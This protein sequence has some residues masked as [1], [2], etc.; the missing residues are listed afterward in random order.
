MARIISSREELSGKLGGSVY[1]RNKGGAY[2]RIFTIPINPRSQ[3]QLAVRNGW[4]SA[5]TA[6]HALSDSQKANWNYFAITDYKPKY[7]KIGISYS[8]FNCF[9]GCKNELIQASRVQTPAT[10]TNTVNTF[11]LFNPIITEAPTMP[12]SA[13]IT[14]G[15]PG[16]TPGSLV[17][18]IKL[19]HASINT[20]TNIITAT[21]EFDHN[22]GPATVPIF[23]DAISNTKC[24][25]VIMQSYPNVQSNQFTVNPRYSFATVIPHP[26]ITSTTVTTNQLTF[27]NNFFVGTKK[28]KPGQGD[29][30]ELNAFLTAYNGLTQPI[31]SVKVTCS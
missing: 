11:T 25:I 12:I 3:G 30:V 9:V 27:T 1:A 8:G 5:V 6:Y 16:P 23:K 20:S 7:P 17:T 13:N 2:V 10:I 26:E 29:V 14:M 15:A 21:F 22:I 31:G 24:G 18:Q 4:A 28:F 19:I